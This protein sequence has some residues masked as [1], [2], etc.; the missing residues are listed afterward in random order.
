MGRGTKVVALVACLATGSTVLASPAAADVRRFGDRDGGGGTAIQ[1]MVVTNGPN[2]VRIQL[3]HKGRLHEDYFWIDSRRRDPGPEYRVAMLANSD[4]DPAAAIER[5]EKVN[6]AG[7]PWRCA[8][9]ADLHSDN[10]E[11]GARSHI[12]IPQRCIAGPG[13]VRVRADSVSSRGVRD[14]APNAG[15]T[16]WVSRG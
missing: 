13:G 15:F 3:A 14:R 5:V 12:A 10:F 4:Y 2:N 1:R 16:S 11:P 7:K 8:A 6:S 9:D